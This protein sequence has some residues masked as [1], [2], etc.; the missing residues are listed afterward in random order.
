MDFIF[1]FLSSIFLGLG[2]AILLAAA[3]AVLFV[4]AF[5]L[6]YL[7]TA[8]LSLFL[9]VFGGYQTVLLVGAS[10][11]RG[12]VDQA[13]TAAEITTETISEN[14]AAAEL[15]D[16]IPGA[17][18]FLSEE[19]AASVGTVA[20]IARRIDQSIAD[21]M[22]RR[23]LWLTVFCA[24]AAGLAALMRPRRPV[25]LSDP[26]AGSPSGGPCDLNF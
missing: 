2:A 16:G 26:Y 13:A 15:L 11:V 19:T 1:N 9:L 14:V 20:A 4:K 12:L 7:R 21:Y 18:A 6:D 8:L 24:A 17:S 3:G 10:S 5:R 22:L 25:P 23:A